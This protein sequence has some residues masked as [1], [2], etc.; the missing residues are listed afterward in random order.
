MAA[1]LQILENLDPRL[2]EML[3]FLGLHENEERLQLNRLL[4]LGV[5]SKAAQLHLSM[6]Q[7]HLQIPFHRWLH[8][9]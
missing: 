4:L 3:L 5:T 8:Q 6:S 9:L 1:V 2:D 7:R